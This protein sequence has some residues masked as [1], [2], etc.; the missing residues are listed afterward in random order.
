M[1]DS[2]VWQSIWHIPDEELWR[3][4]QRAKCRMLSGLGLPDLQDT[5]TL[6]FARRFAT[7]KRALL[8]FRDLGRLE[9]IVNRLEQPVCF[10]F[11]DKAH[12]ADQAGQDL[13]RRI[14]EVSRMDS[15]F[16]NGFE[17]ELSR[18]GRLGWR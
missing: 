10:I 6:G 12:P 14:V 7:Y 2:Q 3:T 9:R 18:W 13:I 4:H 8:V 11:A 1:A 16:S 5:L 17:L 15:F